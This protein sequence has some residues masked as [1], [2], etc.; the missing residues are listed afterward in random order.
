M[1]EQK[2]VIADAA[3]SQEE[4]AE[5][6]KLAGTANVAEEKSNVHNFLLRVVETEDT[7]KVAN[8]LDE[9]LGAAKLPVR[10]LQELSL[11]AEEIGNMPY[12]AKYFKAEGEIILATS[13]SREAKLLEAAITTARQVG[14]IP[15]KVRKK[16]KGWFGLRKD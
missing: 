12:F 2:D 6:A 7:T 1:E 10:T 15:T 16:N 11:F 8:L 14:S 3:L 13:L 4:L 5:L 9:E